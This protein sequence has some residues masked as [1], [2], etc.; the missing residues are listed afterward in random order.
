[1]A[2]IRTLQTT[3]LEAIT[4]DWL[5]LPSGS[6]DASEELAT[7]F[8]IALLTDRL[9]E[10][11]DELP[12]ES[13]DRR[14]WWADYDAETLW[15]GW[16]I[17]ARFWLLSRAKITSETLARAELYCRE[18]LQPFIS[19]KIV[20]R[21]DVALE[22]GGTDAITGTIT[23]WRGPKR[24]VDLRFQDLWTEISSR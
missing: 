18:A 12:D 22:R 19:R 3:T 7:A 17:G 14:G 11:D 4:T 1:M 9:A 6:L 5:V 2:D 15:N 24:A 23:A 16:P 21:I 20:S 8:R 10:A 13:D